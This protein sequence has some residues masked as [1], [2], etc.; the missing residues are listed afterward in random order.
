MGTL[1]NWNE[2]HRPASL[3]DSSHSP[4]QARR[5]GISD[6]AAASPNRTRSHQRTFFEEFTLEH[7]LPGKRI[8][9]AAITGCF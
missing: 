4:R 6:P 7:C 1:N 3:G 8:T 5:P 2:Q 9:F